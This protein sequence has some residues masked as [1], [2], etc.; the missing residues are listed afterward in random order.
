M[1][2]PPYAAAVPFIAVEIKEF[3]SSPEIEDGIHDCRLRLHLRDTVRQGWL[4]R[5]LMLPTPRRPG[6]RAYVRSRAGAAHEVD[7]SA[8]VALRRYYR[9]R[10]P[11][12]GLTFRTL[13]RDEKVSALV[14]ACEQLA[15]EG[16]MRR[17][18]ERDPEAPEDPLWGVLG[19]SA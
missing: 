7:Q 1:P 3:L 14:L 8:I 18:R 9:V 6:T 19:R 2:K 4:L 13:T 10:E 5:M 12:G 17:Y 16:R 11:G 15:R